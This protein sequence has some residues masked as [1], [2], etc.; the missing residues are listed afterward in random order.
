[1]ES[2]IGHYL[3]S[4]ASKFVDKSKNWAEYLD[5]S[6][7]IIQDVSEILHKVT[8]LNGNPTAA[9]QYSRIT[10]TCGLVN[11]TLG[12]VRGIQDIEGFITGKSI[13]EM[14]PNS[15]GSLSKFQTPKSH[16]SIISNILATLARC[17]FSPINWLH[18]MGIHKL[19]THAEEMGNTVV[20]IWAICISLET[21]EIVK[22]IKNTNEYDQMKKLILNFVSNVLDLISLLIDFISRIK[23]RQLA[24]LGIAAS[25]IGL[26]TKS[27]YLLKEFICSS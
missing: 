8:Y 25:A 20:G 11:Q 23:G 6:I 19:G 27:S 4:N 14:Y 13:W 17:V 21:I 2:V 5:R 26:I 3:N 24:P 12:L 1:M 15:Q 18:D 16:M 7:G 22:S 9:Q 10:D